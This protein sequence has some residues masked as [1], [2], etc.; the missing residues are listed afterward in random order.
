MVRIRDEA[1][2]FC[3]KQAKELLSWSCFS[4]LTSLAAMM[5]MEEGAITLTTLLSIIWDDEAVNGGAKG[6]AITI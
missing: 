3:A 2:L 1:Q 6:H 5:E 4:F